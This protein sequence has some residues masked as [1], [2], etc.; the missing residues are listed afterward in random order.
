MIKKTAAFFLCLLFFS[1]E[2]FSVSYSENSWRILEQAQVCFDSGNY[3]DAF[4]YVQ[5]A[6]INRRNEAEN[7]YTLLDKAVAPAQVRKAGT[8]IASVLQVLEERE[9]KEAVSVINKYVRFYGVSYFD[10]NIRNMLSWLKKRTVYPEA[11][12]LTGKIYQLEGEYSQALSFYERAYSERE[13][14]D[15]PDIQYDILYSIAA[16]SKINGDMERLEKSL[17]LILDS[18]EFFKNELLKSSIMKSISA[19]AA[20]NVDRIFL[21]YRAD[22]R[23]SLQ[24]LCDLAYLYE[25]R[26]EFAKSLECYALASIEAF[27]HILNAITERNARFKYTTLEDFF[28][29]SGN[30]DEIT[31]WIANNNIWNIFFQFAGRAGKEGNLVFAKALFAAMANSVPDSYYRAIAAQQLVE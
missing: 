13:Y 1:S 21:L 12:Y 17:L 3:G 16:I 22:T 19:D 2:F 20:E 11:D 26:G 5:E 23:Y 31:E 27:T 29:E 28:A 24:A 7:E 30:Y 8:E 15:I 18:D 9:Q 10:D 14:L 25:M 4:K 6:S